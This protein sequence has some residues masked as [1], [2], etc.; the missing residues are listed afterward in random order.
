MDSP[1]GKYQQPWISVHLQCTPDR[2]NSAGG[3]GS[4]MC[5]WGRDAMHGCTRPGPWL[6]SACTLVGCIGAADDAANRPPIVGVANV[7]VD[8][9]MS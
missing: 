5:V 7:L 6:A 1:T 2:R 9:P 4:P 8:S 3:P